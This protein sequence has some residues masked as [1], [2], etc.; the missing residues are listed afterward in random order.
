MTYRIELS[1]NARKAFLAIPAFE[2]RRVE[3]VIDA[4]AHNPRPRSARKLVGGAGE[5]R[6]RVGT[7]RV[8][9]EVSDDVQCLLVLAIGPRKD[10]YRGR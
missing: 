5:L 9:Y 8:I 4:L 7:Y 10:V 1:R 3:R 2:R 6:L